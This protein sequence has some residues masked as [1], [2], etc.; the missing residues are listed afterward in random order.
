MNVTDTVTITMRPDG[1]KGKGW[2]DANNVKHAYEVQD[3]TLTTDP[4]QSVR[5]CANCGKKQ[6]LV[7]R[8][9]QWED[10]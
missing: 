10:R 1:V 7:H 8:E 2:C 4:P 5:I 3:Y 6:Y 9:P